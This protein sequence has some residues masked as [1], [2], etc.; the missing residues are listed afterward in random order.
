MQL[1]SL[2][3]NE[4]RPATDQ[5]GVV[6]LG[7]NVTLYH[8]DCLDMLPTLAAGS[9]D[10]VVTDPPY[11]IS[12]QHDDGKMGGWSKDT[13]RWANQINPAYAVFEGDDKP[14]DPAPLLRLGR[15]HIIWGGNFVAD[16][17]PPERGWLTWYKRIKGQQNDHGDSELAWTD[18]G[19]VPRT[20]QHLWMGM[21]RDSERG[22]HWH[23]TQKPVAL[24]RWCIEML[25]LQPG[26]TICDPYMG[27]GAT[28]V[29]AV[30]MGYNFIGIERTH[31]YFAIAQR[32]IAE[33]QAQ[34]PLFQ[35]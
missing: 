30:Q 22:E 26:D 13:K 33:A 16:K 35:L 24:M 19:C 6:R 20:F 8:A 1:N 23:P 10:A 9:V 3:G 18:L 12:V 2:P 34:M 32:R 28:G 15:K 17:L 29:A 11:G 4:V 7:Q 21:L 27:A 14:I 25:N 31:H 5:G